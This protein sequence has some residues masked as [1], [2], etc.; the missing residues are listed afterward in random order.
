MIK[1]LRRI[2][3]IDAWYGVVANDDAITHAEE[4]IFIAKNE[5]DSYGMVAMDNSVFLPFVYDSISPLGFNLWQLQKNGK[6]GVLSLKY[7]ENKEKLCIGWRLPCEYDYVSAENGNIVS[8]S[9]YSVEE[10]RDKTTLFFVYTDESFEGGYY[11][12]ISRDYYYV[13]ANVD[14]QMKQF[15]INTKDGK[16][17][18]LNKDY[19]LVGRTLQENEDIYLM[20]KELSS[21]KYL[22][23]RIS[24]GVTME[25]EEYDG[26]PIAI[27]SAD[28]YGMDQAT[29][30]AFVGK[31][32][33]QYYYLD[34]DL[35]EYEHPFADIDIETSLSGRT[36][37]G[38]EKEKVLSTFCVKQIT[39]VYDTGSSKGMDSEIDR[40]LTKR[41]L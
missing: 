18:Y 12:Q 26:A 13:H 20:F 40:I 2:N 29:P 7:D 31:R 32:S 33:G 22:I 6:A 17:H 19:E 39:A 10:N 23:V 27:Y 34:H 9:K 37:N 30:I 24:N 25:S 1:K 3:T 28:A 38:D 41:R 15:M 8:A 36:I 4:S 16:M 5:N 11:D 21:N 35:D 14:G